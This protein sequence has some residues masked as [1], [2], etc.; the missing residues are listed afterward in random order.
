ML[1]LPR[2]IDADA[3]G[4]LDLIE[5]LLINLVLVAVVPGTRD[6]MLVEDAELHRRLP[7][8]RLNAA[9]LL[10]AA[11]MRRKRSSKAQRISGCV[12]I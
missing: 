7:L 2:V 1:D 12:K 6:L 8:Y 3:I 5:R 10:S 9:P 11:R 4:E